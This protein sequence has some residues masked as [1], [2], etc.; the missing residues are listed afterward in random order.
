MT[1]GIIFTVVFVPL[2]WKVL[3]RIN[4]LIKQNSSATLAATCFLYV[5]CAS[6]T[7]GSVFLHT[8]FWVFLSILCSY[9]ISSN[10]TII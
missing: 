7:S 1:F 3:K 5:F 10:K 8:E 9:R 2:F 4:L 6:M